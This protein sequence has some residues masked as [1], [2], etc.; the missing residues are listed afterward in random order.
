M[1]GTA[2]TTT[3]GGAVEVVGQVA[4]ISA[5]LAPLGFGQVA[6]GRGP[7][8]LFVA[9]DTDA[10]RWLSLRLVIGGRPTRRSIADPTGFRS[11]LRRMRAVRGNRSVWV[12]LLGPDGTGKSSLA[13]GLARSLAV[14]AS[15]F[16]GGLYPTGRRRYRLPGIGTAATLI[17]LWRT[18][19]LAIVASRRGR[20]V[21]F[22]R[23]PLDAALPLQGRAGR[24]HRWRSAVLARACPRPD[25]LVILDAPV[26]VLHRRRREQPAAVLEAQRHGY[27]ALAGTIPGSIVIDATGELD[28]VRRQVT[29]VIWRAYVER[30][31]RTA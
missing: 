4:S 11:A 26:H 31:A 23:H 18:T 5:V 20:V 9:Y 27:A 15:R 13:A 7:E 14:P 10:D 6:P 29:D 1:T 12:A 3:W 8:R 22:D 24:L 28:A 16:Y 2:S 30:R 25:L 19:A 21:I 17:R